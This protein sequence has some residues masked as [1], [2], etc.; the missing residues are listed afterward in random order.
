VIRQGIAGVLGGRDGE[1][2]KTICL[3]GRRTVG[4]KGGSPVYFLG[5]IVRKG[6]GA[7]RM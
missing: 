6:R 1:L 5:L 7:K 4:L 3:G 2:L